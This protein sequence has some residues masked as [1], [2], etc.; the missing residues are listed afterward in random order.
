MIRIKD[1][2]AV[3]AHNGE[4]RHDMLAATFTLPQRHASRLTARLVLHAYRLFVILNAL[5]MLWLLMQPQHTLL[6]GLLVVGA[7]CVALAI[8][9]SEEYRWARKTCSERF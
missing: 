8:P 7:I 6:D 5:G 1:R 3:S 2:P 4:H 9:R